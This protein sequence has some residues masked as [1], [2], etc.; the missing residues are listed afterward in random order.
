M[1][2]QYVA[3]ANVSNNTF[4]M[5][6]GTCVLGLVYFCNTPYFAAIRMWAIPS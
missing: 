6:D 4:P 5:F 1:E 2:V 3:D